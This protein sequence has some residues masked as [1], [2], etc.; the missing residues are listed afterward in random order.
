MLEENLMKKTREFIALEEQEGR[1]M[2]NYKD[3]EEE[4]TEMEVSCL[5]RINQLKA[6]KRNATF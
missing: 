3:V 2:R 6:W 5:R 4:M 1:L